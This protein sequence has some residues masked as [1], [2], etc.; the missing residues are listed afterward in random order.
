[1][2]DYDKVLKENIEAIFLPLL[3]KLLGLSIS[4]TEELKDK[5]QTT[6][7]R[8]PDFLKL[9][10]DS[11]G[12][13]F[14]L[15][16]E[17]QTVNDQE[18]VY[19]MAE[20]KAILQR[21][22]QMPVKQ[23]V[24]YLGASKPSMKTKLPKNEQITG[25]QL[26]NIHDLSTDAVLESELPEE[27]ILSILTDHSN[28]D[29]ALILERIIVKLQKASKNRVELERAMKQLLV[30][31]R[32]RNLETLTKEKISSM[33]I[34]YDITKDGLYKEGI[35]AGIEVGIEVGIESGMKKNNSLVITRL[36]AQALLTVDQIAEATN[37]PVEKVLE[38]KASM[39]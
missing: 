19:R 22:Y 4:K 20:Y 14:I 7:E 12:R 28:A 10:L 33:P 15:Q 39:K 31:S 16:L 29:P 17:F 36:L 6:I 24:I 32:L 26:T 27:I 38:I 18:M 25:F 3:E 21:K 23:F 5:I 30:L 37:V 8:E 1:M 9:V 2:G 13:K 35:E 11:D 34:T